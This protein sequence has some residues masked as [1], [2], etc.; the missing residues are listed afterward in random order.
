[1][2]LKHAIAKSE[3]LGSSLNFNSQIIHKMKNQNS[4]FTATGVWI[5][6]IQAFLFFSCSTSKWVVPSGYVGTWT[7]DNHKITVR[8]KINGERHSRFISD[9]AI[10]KLIIKNDKT[11]SGSIGLAKF[12]NG[13][14][15]KNST[16]LWD[17]GIS[18]IIECDTIGKIFQNDPVEAKLVEIW[19][20]PMSE[21]GN[22]KA[23]L[24]L[25]GWSVFP[26]ADLLFKKVND[27]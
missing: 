24:R 21:N 4:A 1:M 27:E 9:S 6:L 22:I 13:K 10:I 15:I 19:L 5:F 16:F 25:G 20:G 2:T 12:E 18:F 17:T 8:Y 14:I 26:M 23:E 7:T 3:L 11:A